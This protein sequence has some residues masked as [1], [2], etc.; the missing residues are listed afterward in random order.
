MNINKYIGIPFKQKG[1]D[2]EGVDCFGL[3]HLFLKEEMGMEIPMFKQYDV[4]EDPIEVA[5]Q[6]NL[7]VPLIA[8]DVTTSPKFG[9]MALF[10]FRG[11]ANHIG[12]YV[13][14]G[15]VL[16]AMRGTESACESI[17]SVRLKGRLENYYELREENKIKYSTTPV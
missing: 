9:D 13:G 12:I 8:G 4:F 17:N 1:Y 7:N 10:K 11:V 3:V 2:F 6:F 5:R 14:N 15:R 16:H